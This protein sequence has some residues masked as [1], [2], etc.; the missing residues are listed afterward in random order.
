MIQIL[1]RPA[2]RSSQTLGWNGIY[3]EQHRQPAWETPEFTRTKHMLLVHGTDVT[4]PTERWFDGR[5]QQ[6][7]IGGENN[8]AIVP[9]TVKHRVNWARESCFSLLFI[10]PDR[11]IQI[12][13][14]SARIERVKLIPHH[15]M[16]DRRSLKLG[17]F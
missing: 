8:I 14:E 12:A 6:E 15:A 9:A 4:V 5:R 2:M 13:Y 17:N 7:Q 3:V 10:E 11:L 1:P 16:H